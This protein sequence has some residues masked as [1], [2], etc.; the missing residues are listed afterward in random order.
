MVREAGFPLIPHGWTT[1]HL[2]SRETAR[3]QTAKGLTTGIQEMGNQRPCHRRRLKRRTLHHRHGFA[4]PA[5]HC[6]T[7]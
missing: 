5:V 6:A 4:T 3:N 2:Q 1:L 7:L